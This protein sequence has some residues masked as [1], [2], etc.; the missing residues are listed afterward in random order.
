MPMS[1]DPTGEPPTRDDDIDYSDIPATDAAFW[2]QA[3]LH[4]APP[5]EQIS[6]RLDSD[7]L[8]WFR[9]TGTGYQT[10]T[11]A[12]LRQFVEHQRKTGTYDDGE[13]RQ[14]GPGGVRRRKPPN[15]LTAVANRD[16]GSL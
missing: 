9:A 13:P 3:A 5:K 4:T 14:P 10:R 7:V 11:N 15:G 12:V 8:D 1:K 6:I 16:P 2:S